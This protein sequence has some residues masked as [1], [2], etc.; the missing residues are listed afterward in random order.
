VEARSDSIYGNVV[1]VD[2]G[3]GYRSR[4]AHASLL[5]VETGREVRKN[6]VIALTGNTGRSTAPHLHFEILR[7][8]QAVDPLT[9]VDPAGS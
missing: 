3:N 2:H 6:E 7:D 4:Y 9:M 5:F 1:V 8:G